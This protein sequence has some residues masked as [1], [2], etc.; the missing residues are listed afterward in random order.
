M[1]F[2]L[3]DADFVRCRAH[4]PP[5]TETI[6]RNE[7][8]PTL[9]PSSRPV[10]TAGRS[11]HPRP[12]HA[13]RHEQRGI[14]PD[15]GNGLSGLP[16]QGPIRRYD[17]FRK[18]WSDRRT[19]W[20]GRVEADQDAV[21]FLGD[22]ITQG[23]GDDFSGWFPGM[24]IANRGISGDTSRGVLIRLKEDVL[25][26]NPAAVVLLIGTNDLEEKAEPETIAG[27]LKLI[28]AE[29]TR[30]NPKMPIVLCHVFPSSAS[31]I[32]PV[33]Q[34][35]GVE[36]ALRRPGEGQ[37][38][39]HASRNLGALCGR[40]GRRRL[41]KQFPDLLHPNQAGLRALAAGLRPIFATLGFL[42]TTPYRV[43]SRAGFREPVQR[44]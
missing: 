3:K 8:A 29:L 26:L 32:A 38:P 41:W 23:W 31:E 16:G 11:L 30:H 21:V 27:N 35:Q 9:H 17:W 10:S 43:H 6:H 34:D 28:L 18:L 14:A 40:A 36:P 15:P 39:G 44:P 5:F 33:R 12:E 24:K 20:A 2:S 37:C 4:A 19:R 1:G 25:A 42:E 22:S 7:H 13:G